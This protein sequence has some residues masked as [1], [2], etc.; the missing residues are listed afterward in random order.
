[1]SKSWLEEQQEADRRRIKRGVVIA[2]DILEIVDA[3][4]GV[5]TVSHVVKSLDRNP[6]S[7][8]EVRWQIRCLLERG[9]LDY[10]D[11]LELVRVEDPQ[12]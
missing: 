6:H 10:G 4:N 5:T 11:S 8:R 1:M 3:T 9:I 7:P 2:A 12:C